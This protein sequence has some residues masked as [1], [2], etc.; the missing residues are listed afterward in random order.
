MCARSRG[1]SSRRGRASS[2][3]G[4][5]ASSARSRPTCGG[6]RSPFDGFFG[7]GAFDQQS[8]PLTTEPLRIQ[9]RGLPEAGRPAG[10]SGSVGDYTLQAQVDD[11]P[12]RQGEPFTL[13]ATVR[14]DG[15]VQTIGQPV[16][17][18]WNGLRVYDS[19]EAVNASQVEDRI[20]GEK[21]FKQ[22]LIA[23]RAGTIALDPVRFTYF[24]PQK[25][26]Y[27]E[28]A[29][30]PL[31]IQV[32][33]A[34]PGGAGARA[35]GRRPGRRRHPLH[36]DGHRVPVARGAHG[37][38]RRALSAG[39]LPLLALGGA[40]FAR[41]RRLAWESDPVRRARR[42]A[43][44][45]AHEAL[46][47]LSA[48]APAP[49]AAAGLRGILEAYLDAWLGAPV[50]GMR[51]S[52]LQGALG[53]AGLEATQIERVIECFE[54]ADEVRLG[55]G[56]LAGGVAG[57][58]AS[59][60]ALVDELEAQRAADRGG[61]D[62]ARAIEAW[63]PL[64]RTRDRRDR[65]RGVGGR[66]AGPPAAMAGSLKSAEDAY[67]AGDYSA[68]I[69]AYREVLAAGWVSASLYYDLGSACYRGGERGWAVFYLEEARRLAPRDPGHPPQPAPRAP[70]RGRGHARA[71]ELLAAR[72]A[73]R[74]A[75]LDHAARLRTRGGCPGLVVRARGLRPLV[76]A[77]GACAMVPARPRVAACAARARTRLAALKA[78]QV[79]SAPSGV[80]VASEVDVR[81][82]PLP[83]ETVQFVLHAGASVKIGRSTGSWREVALSGDMRGWV[84]ADAV[85]ALR[86]PEWSP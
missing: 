2:R 47:A 22:V 50:R 5:D 84:P 43:H 37:H 3:S 16:W 17:P 9:I 77:G 61:G 36:P 31:S 70:G 82:G 72:R 10:F 83:G 26:R 66:W 65:F 28:I 24:D 48:H 40:Y 54:W 45:R 23:N 51:R 75:R 76:A 46:H 8:V 58:H 29:S 49:E 19:G 38:C 20:T 67:A 25:K 11:Q 55:A 81:S 7:R 69:A 56:A 41:R 14:G 62:E 60:G 12:V 6:R 80:I 71:R 35:I 15:H 86:A 42:G 52:E 63:D 53:E 1:P 13:T 57:R 85:A 78:Y 21:G 39:A 30:A 4:P 32:L 44:R 59:L 33:P 34:V 27:I 18:G 68:A 73:R 74:R 79:H 64:R